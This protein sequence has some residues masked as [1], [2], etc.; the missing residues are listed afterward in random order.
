MKFV[1]VRERVEMDEVAVRDPIV[2]VPVKNPAEK[3]RED[4]VA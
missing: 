3:Y 4:V 2:E 1:V